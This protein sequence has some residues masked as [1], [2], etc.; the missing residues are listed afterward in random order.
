MTHPHDS[1]FSLLRNS[2]Q[3]A[4]PISQE[5]HIAMKHVTIS[6]N[7]RR[8]HGKNNGELHPRETV[9]TSENLSNDRLNSKSKQSEAV[10]VV[11][12]EC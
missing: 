11:Q 8:R 1:S 6:E 5:I 4:H 3:F 10:E 7:R 12:N 9:W 2:T